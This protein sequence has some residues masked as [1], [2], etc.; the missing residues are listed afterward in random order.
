MVMEQ[1]GINLH[2]PGQ[3]MLFFDPEYQN[4]KILNTSRKNIINDE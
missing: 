3:K 2:Q 4:T 1:K